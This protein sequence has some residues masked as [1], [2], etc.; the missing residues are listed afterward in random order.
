MIKGV[1][2]ALK[3]MKPGEVR[4]VVIPYGELSYP[5]DDESHDRVGPKPKTFS[6]QRALNFVLDNPRLDRTTLFNLKVIRV[7]K[8]D[9][10]GGFTRG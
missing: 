2:L 6:G 9:G 5:P 10:K 1:E 3:D 4:Q 7:D 8:A